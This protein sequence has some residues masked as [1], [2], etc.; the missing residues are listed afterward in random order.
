MK[1]FYYLRNYM[2]LVGAPFKNAETC[3]GTAF[4]VPGGLFDLSIITIAGRYPEVG[5]AMNETAHEI[6]YVQEGEGTLMKENEPAIELHE[7]DVVSVP[8]GTWFAWEGHMKII[9]TCQPAFDA[10]Q[11]KIKE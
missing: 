9:M 1:D 3:E 4:S 6:V 7:G 5:W 8:P 11:Y 2:K 10:K